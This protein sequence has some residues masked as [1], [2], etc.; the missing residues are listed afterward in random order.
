[1]EVAVVG[2][3]IVGLFTAWHLEKEGVDVTIFDP[4]GAGA[5]SVHAAGIIEPETAYRTNTLAFLRMV[6]R[7]W[8]NGTCTFRWVD[9]RWLVESARQ[10]DRPPLRGMDQSLRKLADSSVATYA[11][12]AA[13]QNDFGYS[14]LG[15]VEHY[16]DPT[17]FAEERDLALSRSEAIPVEV[18]SGGRRGVYSFPRSAGCI[19]SSSSNG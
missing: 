1:V 3:G 19:P 9:P 4:G 15:L 6:W 14:Q 5:G 18:P 8:K 16:D 7:L 12:L 13:R 10:L 17:H 11:S 2:G